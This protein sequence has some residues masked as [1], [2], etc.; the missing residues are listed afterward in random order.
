MKKFIVQIIFFL[1]PIILL[2]YLI[3]ICI[4]AN[5]KKSNIYAQGEFAV[6]NTILD[7]NA[8]T[9][10]AIYG[11][12]R[13]WVHFNS[14]V[15][16]DSLKHPTYN[17]G[18]DGHTLWLEYLRHELLLKKDKAPKLIIHSIDISTLQK[19]KELYN[20]DQFL[21]YMLWNKDIKEYTEDYAGFD[22]F[23][24]YVPLIRYYNKTN[25]IKTS[26]SMLVKQDNAVGR[27]KGYQ[28]QDIQWNGDFDKA[29]LKMKSMKAHI[30]T[31]TLVLF[32]K[33]LNECKQRNI[34]VILVW[35]PEYIEGQKFIPNRGVI[36]DIY[37][38]LSTKY[39]IPFFDFSNDEISYQKKY[40]YNSEHM[41]RTGSVLFTNKLIDKIKKDE[42]ATKVLGNT[43]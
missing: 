17:F 33:Y 34:L 6:W 24:Y 9:E 12:S 3:D 15:I 35:S 2:A 29:K 25:A 40:F 36:V 28:S 41:N 37:K 42:R 39:D 20:S 11:S 18:I 5:L 1:L 22:F 10:I 13:A 30:D 8:K 26:F 31:S 14:T 32:D 7:G 21:P 23:D 16:E 19:L 38:N 4:S 27:I 43:L